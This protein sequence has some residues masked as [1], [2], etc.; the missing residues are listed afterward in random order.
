MIPYRL[1]KFVDRFRTTK[2]V[3]RD[4][5]RYK[6]RCG[7]SDELVVANLSAGE[8]DRP[9]F[10]VCEG[11]YVV[12]IGGNIGIF[13]CRA[14][15]LANRVVTVEP[16]WENFRLLQENIRRNG[17]LNVEA[18]QAAVCD[19]AG[20]I[21]LNIAREGAYHSILD[22]IESATTE[23]VRAITLPEL[24]GERCDLLKVDCE[25]AEHQ[26]FSSLPADVYCRIQRIAMEWHGGDDRNERI[27]QA[28]T[29]KDRLVANGFHIDLFDED[30]GFKSGKIFAHRTS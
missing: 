24:I 4:G 16:N 11:D 18:I 1:E 23:T 12:D 5:L 17:L 28:M 27:A 15:R 29:L 26:I 9:G 14:A 25:G 10:E 7:T 8:Y 22:R 2:T 20:T 3:K 30:F 21:T 13:A 19:H 6:V